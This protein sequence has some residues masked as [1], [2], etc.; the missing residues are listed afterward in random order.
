MKLYRVK[1]SIVTIV[2]CVAVRVTFPQ[3]VTISHTYGRC[4]S[5]LITDITDIYIIIT[6]TTIVINS[7]FANIVI[8]DVVTSNISTRMTSGIKHA[9]YNIAQVNAV[10]ELASTGAPSM[11]RGE[12]GLRKLAAFNVGR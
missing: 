11:R 9:G 3:Y 5:V 7:C 1:G 2:Y 8:T 6:I 10:T 4:I 12:I